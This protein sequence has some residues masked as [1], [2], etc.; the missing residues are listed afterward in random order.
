MVLS[1]QL[2]ILALAFPVVLE[3][4]AVE[5]RETTPALVQ[6]ALRDQLVKKVIDFTSVEGKK[7][8]IRAVIDGLFPLKQ[9][10]TFFKTGNKFSSSYLKII[11]MPLSNNFLCFYRTNALAKLQVPQV[12]VKPQHIRLAREK[13]KVNNIL[14]IGK[15]IPK[16]GEH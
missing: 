13:Y 2:L 14:Q 4:T 16:D 1:L 8:Q 3:G 6:W 5:L 10:A 11:P 7:Y 9:S 12:R 15:R